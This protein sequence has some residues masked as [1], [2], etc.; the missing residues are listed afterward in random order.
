MERKGMI[1]SVHDNRLIVRV[2]R[3][4]EDCTGCK[5]CSLSA[6]CKGRDTGHMDLP[7]MIPEGERGRK[8]YTPGDEVTVE[9]GAAN[10]ALAAA[11]MFAPALAG[12]ALGGWLGN[13]FGDA[14]LLAGCGLGFAAGVGISWL[15]GKKAP[16][17]RP[18]V[19]L[20]TEG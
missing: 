2:D 6:L 15:L 3:A 19:H 12:L 11:A 7:V 17:L 9:Y 16:A 1:L 14:M 18:K 4:G 5:A 20:V 10:A 8:T 13:R